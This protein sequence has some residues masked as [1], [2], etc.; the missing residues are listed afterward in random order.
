MS[1]LQTPFVE[2]LGTGREGNVA[3]SAVQW[4]KQVSVQCPAAFKGLCLSFLLQ[5]GKGERE[6][7]I[8]PLLVV[9]LVNLGN[10]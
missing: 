1:N 7:W 9:S 4:S 10:K 8:S 2:H 3:F 5:G 6:G